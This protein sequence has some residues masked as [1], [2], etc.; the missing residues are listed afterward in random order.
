[1]IR[2]RVLGNFANVDWTTNLGD[3]SIW[4]EESGTHAI[5]KSLYSEGLVEAEPQRSTWSTPSDATP[6]SVDLMISPSDLCT[7]PPVV[8]IPAMGRGSAK[9]CTASLGFVGG[10]A[11]FVAWCKNFN[12]TAHLERYDRIDVTW[13]PTTIASGRSSE[14]VR[15]TG[16][17]EA[18]FLS[19]EI[20]STRATFVEESKENAR[21]QG[22]RR[23]T[24]APRRLGGPVRTRR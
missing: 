20:L 24:D 21:R 12:A 9:T 2:G 10:D 14:L 13:T 8:L 4:A 18:P 7:P 23:S 11:L 1:M 15:A 17:P 22:H 19:M 5:G 3:L 16:P 6:T